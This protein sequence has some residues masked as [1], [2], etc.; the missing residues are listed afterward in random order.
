MRHARRRD[1][2]NIP[3]GR[4]TPARR[5]GASVTFF[6]RICDAFIAA[7]GVSMSTSPIERLRVTSCKAGFRSRSTASECLWSNGLSVASV[8]VYVGR[9]M[10]D[11]MKDLHRAHL[12]SARANVI[13]PVQGMIRSLTFTRAFKLRARPQGADRR[14]RY[15]SGTI[16]PRCPR[17]DQSSA[18]AL[19]P[20]R[21]R[22]SP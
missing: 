8:S 11:E 13:R 9:G 22:G 3:S 12:F 21:G 14:E 10:V 6:P 16:R 15:P 2:A 7:T 20:C 1:H 4:P 18:R 19:A 17:G 5:K